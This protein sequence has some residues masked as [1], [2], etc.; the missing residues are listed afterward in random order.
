MAQGIVE[1]QGS[2]K[3]L[4]AQGSSLSGLVQ[5]LLMAG[6][7]LP[8]FIKGILKAQMVMVAGD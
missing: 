6:D 3:S 5:H 4:Q 7:S 8:E 1:S 2:E